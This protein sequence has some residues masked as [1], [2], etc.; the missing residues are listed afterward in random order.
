MGNSPDNTHR[1]FLRIKEIILYVSDMDAQV[2][3]YRDK[4]GLHVVHPV[5]LNSYKDEYWVLFETGECRLALH[6]G[7]T[8]DLGAD[9]P[10]IVFGVTNFDA[11]RAHLIAAGVD[12]GPERSPAPGIRVAD[13]KDIEGNHFSIE[14]C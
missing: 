2:S 13:G 1:M 9:A 7:G 14:S 5:G 3:F 8:K 11:A 6:G 12:M 4:L 10:K